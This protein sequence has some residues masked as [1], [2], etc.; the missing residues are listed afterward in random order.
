M[1]VS[2]VSQ[3]HN[4]RGS[5]FSGCACKSVRALRGIPQISMLQHIQWPGFSIVV[6]IKVFSR[7]LAMPE[8]DFWYMLE[9]NKHARWIQLWLKTWPITNVVSVFRRFWLGISIFA[10]FSYC[11]AVL[12]TPRCPPQKGQ[13]YTFQFGMLDARGEKIL[14]LKCPSGHWNPTPNPLV[15]FHLISQAAQAS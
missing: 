4:A 11:I 5:P 14:T 6:P 8:V 13:G 3:K 12:G 1:F 15:S 10:N 2:Q 9:L 7:F